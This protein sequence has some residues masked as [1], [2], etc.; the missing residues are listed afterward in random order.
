MSVCEGAPVQKP[1]LPLTLLLMGRSP[2]NHVP[3]N[4]SSAG[5]RERSSWRQGLHQHLPARKQTAGTHTCTRQT[6]PGSLDTG[7][8]PA[9]LFSLGSESPDRVRWSRITSQETECKVR[10]TRKRSDI[11]SKAPRPLWFVK[12]KYGRPSYWPP[13]TARPERPRHSPVFTGRRRRGPDQQ[14]ACASGE[15]SF[16]SNGPSERSMRLGLI[17]G[18]LKERRFDK[19]T[20]LK[21]SQFLYRYLLGF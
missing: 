6:P 21:E 13:P 5:S 18:D 17:S 14:P 2:H 15:L 12:L 11:L 16:T 19:E 8:C 10:E 3:P 20:G 9:E 7:P 1:G 4:A